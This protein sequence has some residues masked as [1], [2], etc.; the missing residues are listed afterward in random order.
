MKD[1]QLKFVVSPTLVRWLKILNTLE[2]KTVTTR[3]MLAHS[4]NVTERTILNDMKKLKVYFYESIQIVST[5]NGYDFIKLDPVLFLKQK[6]KL[7]EN[8][9][10]FELVGNVFYGELEEVSELIERFD[11]SETT[12]RRYLKQISPVLEEYNLE[13]RLDPIDLIGNEA[14]IR[15]FFKDFYYEGEMTPHTLVPPKELNDIVKNQLIPNF[16]KFTI[17]TGISPAEFYYNLYIAIERVR[18]GKR[19]IVPRKLIEHTRNSANYQFFLLLELEIKKI[20]DVDLTETEFC[21]LYLITISKRP[22][23]RIDQEK[24]FCK[25]F[26]LHNSFRSFTKKYI[27]SC[28]PELYFTE[29]YWIIKAFFLSKYIN[30]LITPIQNKVMTE[31][32]E[33]TKL[34]NVNEYNMNYSFL[35]PY[36]CEFDLTDNYLE[37]I[38][39]SLTL[40][41]IRLKDK[42]LR[43]RLRIV[44]LLEGDVY[45]CQNIFSKALQYFGERHELLLIK[46]QMLT[47]DFFGQE[48][49]DLIVTNYKDYLTEYIFN[50]EY[51]LLKTVPDNRDWRLLI[52]KIEPQLLSH[53]D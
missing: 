23:D 29:A 17:G 50:H 51:L 41:M 43:K 31:I 48:N 18:H 45:L 53:F 26:L 20:Y 5:N 19:V 35:T 52:E 38:S 2:K 6:E 34:D 44:F 39:T 10:L 14:N 27:K 15:K 32:I 42:Y 46:I 49:I 24:L 8:E 16:S 33:K 47:N 11:L 4:N 40:L 12:F 3:G 30:H 37:D 21:W 36:F 9:V 1:L 25:D 22:L 28:F 7:L 13:L